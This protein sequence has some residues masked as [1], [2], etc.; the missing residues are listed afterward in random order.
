MSLWLIITFNV[1]IFVCVVPFFWSHPLLIFGRDKTRRSAKRG[2]WFVRLVLVLVGAIGLNSW[3]LV[4]L[5]TL[6]IV[7]GLFESSYKRSNFRS[8]SVHWIL[9][10]STFAGLLSVL[11]YCIGLPGVAASMVVYVV[12]TTTL[13]EKH[14]LVSLEQQWLT[15][16]T[17]SWFWIP[18]LMG[19]SNI[20]TAILIVINNVIVMWTV[21]RHK[22]ED[23]DA[24]KAL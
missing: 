22:E 13:L 8:P 24:A 4:V 10:S 19:G 6:F 1:L 17:V 3:A 14:A 5:T 7:M 11:S 2:L 16:S 12:A 18:A 20:A 23:P 15:V 9:S 21:L